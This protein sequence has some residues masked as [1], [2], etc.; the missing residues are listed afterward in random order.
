MFVWLQ[1]SI[2]GSYKIQF[3]A[4]SKLLGKIFVVTIKK[5]ASHTIFIYGNCMIRVFLTKSFSFFFS[6][7][8]RILC[9]NKKIF[10][11]KLDGIIF[12]KC[13]KFVWLVF[14]HRLSLW[15]CIISIFGLWKSTQKCQCRGVNYKSLFFQSLEAIKNNAPMSKIMW[16]KLCYWG[17]LIL[18][19]SALI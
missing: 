2:C 3:G 17:Q 18:G 5:N 1:N 7:I 19:L 15:N 16:T 4:I 11:Q 14:L 8:H 10:L 12:A 9:Q 6:T 13:M